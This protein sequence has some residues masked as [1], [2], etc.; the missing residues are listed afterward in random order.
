MDRPSRSA[1]DC[2]SNGALDAGIRFAL[3]AQRVVARRTVLVLLEDQNG[4][5]GEIEPE[6]AVGRFD[7]VTRISHSV[8]AAVVGGLR[9]EY[10]A[11]GTGVP[12][13][14][15]AVLIRIPLAVTR[16]DYNEEDV[17][18][19]VVSFEGY[20]SVLAVDVRDLTVGGAKPR[21]VPA[22]SVY[23]A[24][25]ALHGG[26]EVISDLE[27]VDAVIVAG[28]NDR[29]PESVEMAFCSHEEHRRRGEGGGERPGEPRFSPSIDVCAAAEAFG[30]VAASVILAAINL[31]VRA[32]EIAHV[33]P[34]IGGGKIADTF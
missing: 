3:R 29:V 27:P 12:S 10:L 26:A 4:P 9:V 25:H 20:D 5:T 31:I 14:A 21:M 15:D 17:A 16:V 22:E 34:M 13:K 23:I 24:D 28:A 19:A 32:R 6:L 33:V 7:G 8:N 30:D 2:Q 1:T 11:P 18:L